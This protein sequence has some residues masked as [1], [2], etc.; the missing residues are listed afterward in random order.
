MKSIYENSCIFYE[1]ASKFDPTKIL[2]SKKGDLKKIL[3]YRYIFEHNEHISKFTILY[4]SYKWCP[5][6]PHLVEW[7][8][9]IFAPPVQNYST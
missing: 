5:D 9:V 2:F 7:L 4:D 6:L 3:G 1:Q 8:L